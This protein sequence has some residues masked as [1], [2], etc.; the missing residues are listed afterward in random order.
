MAGVLGIHQQITLRHHF[1][2]NPFS[3]APNPENLSAH[4]RGQMHLGVPN[5]ECGLEEGCGREGSSSL[6]AKH[7]LS[8]SKDRSQGPGRRRRGAGLL[9]PRLLRCSG[10]PQPKDSW[11][12]AGAKNA[13]FS[14]LLSLLAVGG[15][16]ESP[17][18]L[19]RALEP[20]WLW[21]PGHETAHRRASAAERGWGLGPG[22]SARPRVRAANLPPSTSPGT[23]VMKTTSFWFSILKTP[24]KG[25]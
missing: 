7:F 19:S 8:Q 16:A 24:L 20:S 9:G 18:P 17:E 5:S 15:R 3:V 2:S 11:A 23:S 4:S 6:R 14:F 12:G 10:C 13:K 21:A 22:P 1:P 25:F